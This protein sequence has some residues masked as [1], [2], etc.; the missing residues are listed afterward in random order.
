[1]LSMHSS[2]WQHLCDRDVKRSFLDRGGRS[3]SYDELLA[4]VDPSI[5]ELVTQS[6]WD[7]TYDTTQTAL[8]NLKRRLAEHRPDIVL[9]I[10]DDEDEIIH[11][12][13]R[14]AI[15]VYTNSECPIVPRTFDPSDIVARES[16]WQWG[17][18]TGTYP[19]AADLSESLLKSL[20]EQDF[21]VAHSS[22]FDSEKGM[23]HGFGFLYERLMPEPA[24]PIVPL[25]LN[26]HWPPNQPTPRRFWRIG[27]AARRA[28][29][30][31]P[32]DLRVAAIATGG[33]SVGRLDEELD[34]RLLEAIRTHDVDTLSALPAG[35]RR[36]STGEVHAWMAA[37]GACEHLAMDFEYVP[38]Y[39]SAGGTGC[40][41][42]FA[43]WR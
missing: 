22:G 2:L 21:D 6:A 4:L 15:L 30:Q 8:A 25:I 36:R 11:A 9:F 37:G 23:A 32:S 35:W 5:A 24:I 17:S 1:M 41:L 26:V 14:P 27:Q 38:G 28:V 29:E 33:L 20:I 12:D 43:T 16:S 34:R 7:R 19:V 10:G 13:N 3:I 18:R 42:G 39:R 40:G 31:W